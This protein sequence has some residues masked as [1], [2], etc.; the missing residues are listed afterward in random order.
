MIIKIFQALLVILLNIIFACCSLFWKRKRTIVLFGGWFG[1]QYRDNPRFLFQYLSDN[2]QKLGLEHVV[3]VSRS[4]EVVELIN[5][6]GYEAYLMSS[7]QS[8]HYHKYA[9]YHIICQSVNNIISNNGDILGWLSYGAIKLNLWHGSGAVKNVNYS[10]ITNKTNCNVSKYDVLKMWLHD[11]SYLFRQFIEK[12]GGWA[13]CYYLSSSSSES[14][15]LQMFFRISRLKCIESNLP[16]NCILSNLTDRE[17]DIFNQ[18]SNDSFKILYLPT[19]REKSSNFN[20]NNVFNEIYSFIKD[21]DCLWIQKPH[22]VDSVNNQSLSQTD[23]FLCLDSDFE[24]NIILPL[25]D[26]IITD[27]SS[28][29]VDALFHM[30]P[31]I[32]YIPDYDEYNTLDRG[33]CCDYESRMCGY[34]AYNIDELKHYIKFIMNNPND[35]F[36]D[37][38]LTERSRWWE[39]DSTIDEIWKD[40]IEFTNTK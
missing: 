39:H 19:F 27:Y 25:A 37:R 21:Y 15:Q 2:K 38:Y 23:R 5:S 36:N 14:D 29:A 32:F 34:K 24:I 31:I 3:W 4:C 11:H 6:L 10:M 1:N 12:D 40:I 7:K 30:I 17:R 18:V 9:K 28:V 13:H 22:P 16:R 35:S 8:I 26:I 33:F 20:Y